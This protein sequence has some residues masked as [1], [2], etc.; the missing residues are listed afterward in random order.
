MIYEAILS[1]FLT[2]TFGVLLAYVVVYIN[3]RKEWDKTYNVWVCIAI[4]III[5]FLITTLIFM[6]NK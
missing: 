1:I 5:H 2:I 4:V 6:L 3:K